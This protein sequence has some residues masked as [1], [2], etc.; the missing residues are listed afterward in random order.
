MRKR[1]LD[2][3]KAGVMTRCETVA[4]RLEAAARQSDLAKARRGS[5]GCH[6]G[7]GQPDMVSMYI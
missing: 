7:G 6:G 3:H 2:R 1:N 5:V 4:R